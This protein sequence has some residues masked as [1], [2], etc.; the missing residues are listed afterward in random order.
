[1]ELG[2]FCMPSH[3]PERDL[4][5]GHD[6][7]LHVFRLLDSLD[8]SEIWVGEHHTVAWEP[9]PAPDLLIAQ[10]LLQT[11]RIRIGPGGFLLPY[12]H[13]AE[14]ANRVAMLD[15]LSKGRLNFGVA[16]SAVETDLVMFNMDAKSGNNRAATREAL[17]IILRLWREDEP[18]H[19]EGRFWKIDKPAPQIGGLLKPHI[20]PLQRP[21][22]PIGIA[23]MSKG[24]D[25]LKLAGE[26]GFLPMSVNIHGNHLRDH[27]SAVEEGANRSGL[28]PR[29]GDWRLIRDVFVAETDEAAWRQ[30][31]DG[32]MGRMSREYWLSVFSSYGFLSALKHDPSVPDTD[33]T[34]EYCARHDWIVGSPATVAARIEELYE[35]VGGFGTLL[36][37]GYDYLDQPE[38]WETSLQLLSTE[39]LPRVR[40]L[41]PK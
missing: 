28:T 19:F 33:V 3:P 20:R 16:A 13:P 32:M 18:F 38:S 1:M 41:W 5:T 37:I 30:S 8:F 22:P 10:A 34:T 29:R 2:Y 14:L 25:T 24:S 6:W 17:D 23:G 4:K 35:T 21:H 36:V 27:W 31:V 40:H 39:V 15:H 9:H 11:S 26:R 7:D 12:H